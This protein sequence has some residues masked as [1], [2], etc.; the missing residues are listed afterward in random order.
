[1]TEAIAEAV[2]PI[3]SAAVVGAGTMGAGIAMALANAGIPVLLKEADQAALDRGLGNVRLNYANSVKHGRFTQQF[4]DERLA[5]IAPTLAYEGFGSVDLVIEA[6]FEGMQL[7]KEVFRQLDEVCKPG[8]ILASNTSTLS[9]DEIA[10]AVSRPQFVVGTHFFTPPNVTRLLEVVRGK[11][12]SPEVIATCLQLARKLGKVGVVVGNCMGFVG[13][14]MF[15]PYHRE[16]QFLIEEGA[17]VEGV[18]GALTAFGMGLG[19]LATM[20]MVGLDVARR[21]RQEHAQE[22]GIRQP[23]VEDRLCA[24]GR[25]GRKTNAGWYKYDQQRRPVLDPEVAELIRK[26]ATEEGIVPRPISSRE[27]LDRCLWTLVNEGARI[28]EE[29]YA[30]SVSDIDTIFLNG[31]GF[32]ASRGGPMKYADSV[33]LNVVY[34]RVLEFYREYGQ[35]WS[36]APLL[37][38]LA[39]QGRSFSE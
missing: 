25:Y 39:E 35:I 22:A 32:P 38:Q 24:L 37:K 7:K 12:T 15:I 8:A 4:V 3:Y 33:G 20:D 16:V 34:H 2:L 19:P 13:N 11:Q 36:P 18:D 21:I 10:S 14:R 6:V 27:I 1:M 5:L 9:I 29:G 30:T 23:F 17:T 31:Y 28:L 26:W